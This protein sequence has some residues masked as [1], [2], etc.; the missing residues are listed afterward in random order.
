MAHCTHRSRPL[1]GRIIR[2]AVWSACSLTVLSAATGCPNL[3]HAADDGLPP[4]FANMSDATNGGAAHVGS[5][6]CVQCHAEVA[7][8]HALHGH[9]QML[10]RIE[11]AA[12]QYPQQAARAG[13]V[14]PPAGFGWSDIS[15][16]IGGYTKRA[17]FIDRDGFVL[18]DGTAGVPTQWT[19]AFPPNG[20]GAGF[21]AYEPDA[22]EPTPYAPNCFECHTTGPMRRHAGSPGFQENRP[23][24]MGTWVEAGIQCE[25]CHGPGSGHF[26]SVGSEVRIDRTRIFVDPTGA[27]SCG[28]CH[29]RTPAQADQPIL[30]ARGF[31]Q[32]QQQESELRASGGHAGFTC[33]TCHDPHASVTADRTNAIRNQCSVCHSDQ[34]L[35]RH[36]GRTY[37]AANGYVETLSCE[38]CHMTYA[39]RNASRAVI[40]SFDA[41]DGRFLGQGRIGDTRTH[42]FRINTNPVD[43]TAMFSEDGSQVARDAEGM[44]A[45]TVDFVCLRCHNGQGS[46]FGLSVERAAEIAGEIHSELP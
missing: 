1:R 6:S 29:S 9:S 27:A 36:E 21:V 15:Y 4:G 37:V 26:T 28:T 32:Y 24:F 12:P 31:V 41:A 5:S 35:A 22:S 25:S 30:A 42:I 14:D 17:L 7:E 2:W 20:T 34:N 19:L 44:A 33:T 39:T 8:R 10:K 13:V 38:S 16:V 23:G 11:G 46:V 40:D 45:V 43:Y 3:F 18:T